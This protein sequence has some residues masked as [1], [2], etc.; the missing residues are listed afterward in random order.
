MAQLLQE[1]FVCLSQ[2]SQYL[3]LIMRGCLLVGETMNS[4]ALEYSGLNRA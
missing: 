2:Q 3:D 1:P 4:T